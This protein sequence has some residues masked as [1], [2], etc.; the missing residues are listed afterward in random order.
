MDT[1][2]RVT[3]DSRWNVEEGRD[4]WVIRYVPPRGKPREVLVHPDAGHAYAWRQGFIA[5]LE[6]GAQ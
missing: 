6:E 4:E 2:P 5:G 1:D 3:V